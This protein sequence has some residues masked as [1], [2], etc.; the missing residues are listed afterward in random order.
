MMVIRMVA[1]MISMMMVMM[2]TAT[3]HV[4][5]GFLVWP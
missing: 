5:S 1:L 2:M 4:S 3:I